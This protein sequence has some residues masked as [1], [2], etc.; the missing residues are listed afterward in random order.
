VDLIRA[1]HNIELKEM[2]ELP[3]LP[4]ERTDAHAPHRWTEHAN[5][6][7]YIWFDYWCP[8]TRDGEG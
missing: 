1:A 8:G 3:V 7:L 4:C 6:S 2:S 5:G